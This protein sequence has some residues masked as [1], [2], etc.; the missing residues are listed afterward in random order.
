MVGDV[1]VVV[2]ILGAEEPSVIDRMS[3]MKNTN[4]KPYPSVDDI[5]PRRALLLIN[6]E[7]MKCTN[8]EIDADAIAISG[9]HPVINNQLCNSNVIQKCPNPFANRVRPCERSSLGIPHAFK[10]DSVKKAN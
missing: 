2:V 6:K 1:D 3:V 8:P 9:F 7:S 5:L 4:Q 10:A